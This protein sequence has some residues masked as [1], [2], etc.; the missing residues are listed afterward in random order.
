MKPIKYGSLIRHVSGLLTN[1][2]KA[3]LLLWVAEIEQIRSKT[4]SDRK[5][6]LRIIRR[7]QEDHELYLKSV[8]LD[9]V[10]QRDLEKTVKT[11]HEGQVTLSGKT[12]EAYKMR[13]GIVTVFQKAMVIGR[14]KDAVSYYLNKRGR[15][16]KYG[17]FVGF[18]YTEIPVIPSVQP[19]T[20]YTVKEPSIE[21]RK[22][23]RR[24]NR[25]H[26]IKR[27]DYEAHLQHNTLVHFSDP[28]FTPKTPKERGRE[29]DIRV[30]KRMRDDPDYEIQD[31][32]YNKLLEDIEDES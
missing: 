1:E 21:R 2:E 24:S 31:E 25:R 32:A 15:K 14:P 18:I 16:N 26:G 27:S 28:D 20:I 19:V 6:E 5:E 17:K 23:V 9:I 10:F 7:S 29:Y 30:A 13:T 4:D 8:L 12:R 11:Y 3:K 22:A